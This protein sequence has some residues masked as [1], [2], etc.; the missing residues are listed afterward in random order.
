MGRGSCA[1]R[2]DDTSKTVFGKRHVNASFDGNGLVLFDRK[3]KNIRS[4]TPF[5]PYHPSSMTFIL[6]IHE[7]DANVLAAQ[8]YRHQPP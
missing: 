7:T 2:S 1:I 6:K 8:K 4:S 5:L 3:Y